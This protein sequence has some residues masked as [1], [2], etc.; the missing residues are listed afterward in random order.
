MP[1]AHLIYSNLYFSTGEKP[2]RCLQH[3]CL[4]RFRYKGDLSKHIRKYHPGHKQELV[5]IPLQE[6][7]LLTLQKSGLVKKASLPVV[8]ASVTQ[9]VDMATTAS[10][11]ATTPSAAAVASSGAPPTI[12][13]PLQDQN[14]YFFP[15]LPQ[16]PVK[17]SELRGIELLRTSSASCAPT[18]AAAAAARS[19]TIVLS[20]QRQQPAAQEKQQATPIAAAIVETLNNS[21]AGSDDNQDP[22]LDDNIINMLAAE[23]PSPPPPQ[24]PA[25]ALPPPLPQPAVMKPPSFPPPSSRTSPVKTSILHEALTRGSPGAK[26]SP[27]STATSSSSTFVAPSKLPAPPPLAQPHQQQTVR[28]SL[29]SPVKSSPTSRVSAAAFHLAQPG[30]A[31][32]TVALPTKPAPP[33]AVLATKPITTSVPT[34]LSLSHGQLYLD[35]NRGGGDS[36]TS[37]MS[38]QQP[39]T[40][41]IDEV[42]ASVKPVPIEDVNGE[43]LRNESSKLQLFKVTAPLPP[44]VAAAAAAT[45]TLTTTQPTVSLVCPTMS[46]TTEAASMAATALLPA[47]PSKPFPCDFPGCNRSF[48]KAN[49][50]R[51]HSKLHSGD[52]RSVCSVCSKCFESQSKLDD[53]YRKHT[54]EKPFICNICGSSFRYK[55][56]YKRKLAAMSNN[57]DA[58]INFSLDFI[59][60]RFLSMA[61]SLSGDRTKHLK[62][63]HGVSTAR[64]PPPPLPAASTAASPNETS[65]STT[66]VMSEGGETAKVGM[67]AGGDSSSSIGKMPSPM[68]GS[69]SSA[70]SAMA[71]VGMAKPEPAET[72]PTPPPSLFQLP[73]A[74]AAPTDS[75]SHSSLISA[76]LP[77][78]GQPAATA[79]ETVTIALDE[80]MQ[81]AQPTVVTEYY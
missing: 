38:T 25:A 12:T 1:Y 10:R 36:T 43:R 78:P 27:V 41:T 26:K 4:K 9:R 6:D 72:S 57:V 37:S 11:V 17:P 77:V 50:L 49:L 22:S 71:R 7:E 35:A 76:L 51:R 63:L 73:A 62:N 24:R 80:V 79:E 15:L 65:T 40:L 3:A 30:T 23:E 33:S 56:T 81:F 48:E 67:D 21:G 64:L 55:G 8:T 45:T 32:V 14:K 42:L 66:V 58:T 60:W 52:C 46:V 28:F 69:E 47:R 74:S 20:Q 13:M 68:L 39:I 16:H 18:A 44:A 31:T 75:S 5:P 54:G 19:A 61:V 59:N 53:H 2:Y 70:S 34:S 29:Q